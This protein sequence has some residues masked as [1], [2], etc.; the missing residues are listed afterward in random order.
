VAASRKQLG[1]LKN[2]LSV[3]PEEAQEELSPLLDAYVLMLGNSRLLRGARKRIETELL[4][5]ETAVQDEAEAI[6]AAI[7]ANRDDDKAGLK[8]RADEVREIARRLTRNLTATPFRSLKDIPQGA[9]LVAEEITPPTPPCWTPRA[10]PASPRRRAA[11]TATPPSCSARSAYPPCWAAPACTTSGARRAGGAGRHEG[12]VVLWP[13][14]RRWS[15]GGSRCPPSPAERAKLGKLRRL[16]G[17]H[18]GRRGG[19]AASQPGDPGRAAADRPGRA[20][21][22]SGCSAPSSCS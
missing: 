22:A 11:P 21:R 16:P 18:H 19:G 3:L 2:R 10:S 14:E 8:R 5:A 7:L 20:P 12:T 4:C 13:G 15:A 9:I 6:A 1:K 17:R